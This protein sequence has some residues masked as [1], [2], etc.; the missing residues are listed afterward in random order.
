M[1]NSTFVQ[2]RAAGFAK[3]LQSSPDD[4]QRVNEA[5]RIAL[6]RTPTG[7]EIDEALTYIAETTRRE[8][9]EQAWQSWC[10]ILLSTNEFIYF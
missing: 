5:Y 4:R 2:A 9:A 10:H 3:R 8:N 1:M 7:A 6:A